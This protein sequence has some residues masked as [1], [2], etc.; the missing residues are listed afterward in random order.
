MTLQNSETTIRLKTLTQ[1]KKAEAYSVDVPATSKS[2][3]KPARFS[4][5][6]P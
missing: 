1:T 3:Q 2:S 5:K 6:K 4:A